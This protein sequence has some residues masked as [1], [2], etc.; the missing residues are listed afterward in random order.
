M[1]EDDFDIP[2][3]WRHLSY[4]EVHHGPQSPFRE[5]KTTLG[6][7]QGNDHSADDNEIYTINWRVLGQKTGMIF[8][9][10]YQVWGVSI[11]TSPILLKVMR[12]KDVVS[13]NQTVGRERR[14]YKGG[15]RGCRTEAHHLPL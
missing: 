15:G 12:Q 13:S 3:R 11:S 5:S 9:D 14:S 4:K 1:T 2:I 8:T 7:C 6:Y 10:T